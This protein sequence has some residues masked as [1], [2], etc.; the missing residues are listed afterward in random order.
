MLAILSGIV[1]FVSSM[2][3]EVIN[4]IRE[5]GD[6]K[7][8]LAIMEKQAQLGLEQSIQERARAEV[9]A[10]TELAKAAQESYRAEILAAQQSW[11]ACYS[12]SVRPTI[13][14]AFFFL[15]AFVKVK[16]FLLASDTLPTLPMPWQINDSL[17]Q[18][19][20]E[21]DMMMFSWIIGFWYGGRVMSRIKK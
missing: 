4:L 5:R 6:K 12:A 19:W 14:Y 17:S 10:E 18:V 16:I 2:V 13:T 15:Y 11:I 20:T 3:P 1:G 21:N 7:H 9:D 8:E